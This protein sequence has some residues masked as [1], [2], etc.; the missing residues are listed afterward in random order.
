MDTPCKETDKI[1]CL[2]CGKISIVKDLERKEGH[3]EDLS[4]GICPCLDPFAKVI[5]HKKDA[6]PVLGVKNVEL[7]ESDSEQPA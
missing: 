2:N 3:L 7:V 6:P 4:F 5:Y 1:K